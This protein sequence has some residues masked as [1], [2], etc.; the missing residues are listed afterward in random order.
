MKAKLLREHDKRLREVD[1]I[2]VAN[3]MIDEMTK[4]FQGQLELFRRRESFVTN[5]ELLDLFVTAKNSFDILGEN[6]L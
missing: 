6:G 2:V 3:T 5:A 1:G 4:V